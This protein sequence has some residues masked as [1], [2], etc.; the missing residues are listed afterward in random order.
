ME[1]NLK[2]EDGSLNMAA[3]QKHVSEFNEELLGSWSSCMQ[4]KIVRHYGSEYAACANGISHGNWKDILKCIA[5]AKGITNPVTW[6][7]T[8]LAYFT[9]WSFACMF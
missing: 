2:N 7:P 9:G 8:Q 3:I 6:I 1:N 5:T 4:G